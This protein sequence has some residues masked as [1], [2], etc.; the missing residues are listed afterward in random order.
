MPPDKHFTDKKI[1]IHMKAYVVVLIRIPGKS[2]NYLS[3]F[4]SLSG[5]I[6]DCLSESLLPQS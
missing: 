2:E 1:T 4:P 5:T 6:T 3:V